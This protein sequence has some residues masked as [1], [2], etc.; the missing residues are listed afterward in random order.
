M[1]F[2]KE[3]F[4]DSLVQLLFPAQNTITVKNPISELMIKSKEAHKSKLMDIKK[5][6]SA[7]HGRRKVAY[8][9]YK[10]YKIS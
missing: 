1:V 2:A 8:I 9:E 4:I 7:K 10:P 5:L 3:E 6:A